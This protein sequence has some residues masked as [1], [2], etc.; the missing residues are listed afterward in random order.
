[1]IFI[2]CALF[3][4]ASDLISKTRAKNIYSKK[5]YQ[6]NNLII[7]IGGVGKVR[8]ESSIKEAISIFGQPKFVIGFGVSG[9]TRT[10]FEK[11]KIYLATEVIDNETKKYF[12]PMRVDGFDVATLYT[13]EKPVFQ[14]QAARSLVDMESSVIFECF[15][16]ERVVILRVVSDY[17]EE[18]RLSKKYLISI[19]S[20]HTKILLDLIWRLNHD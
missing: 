7:I 3:C 13:H 2:L 11:E 17:L 10:D 18:K 12:F 19:M 6:K 9:A 14:K 4:E 8:M 5:F 20:K 16:Q 15:A 1:M